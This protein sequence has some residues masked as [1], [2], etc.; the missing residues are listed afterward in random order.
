MNDWT[1][2]IDRITRDPRYQQNL[3]WGEP[4]PGHPEGTIRAHIA[5]IESNLA[6]IRGEIS[7]DDFRK[8]RVLAHVHDAFKPQSTKG[9]AISDPTSHASLARAFLAEFTSDAD[10]LNIVQLHDEP[11]ALYRQFRDRGG[12]NDVRLR[13]L[14]ESIT[15]HDL[16]A[17]FVMIDGLTEGKDGVPVTWWLAEITKHRP[18]RVRTD[19]IA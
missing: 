8:L 7:E 16:F 11:Y 17:A 4:R 10:M 18:V 12:V 9:V 14:I 6:K 15:D 1:D 3:D 13:N 19:W 2:I 5:Q